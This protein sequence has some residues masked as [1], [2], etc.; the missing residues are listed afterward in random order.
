MER[1][2]TCWMVK[3]EEVVEWCWLRCWWGEWPDSTRRSCFENE[4]FPQVRWR[5][6]QWEGAICVTSNGTIERRAFVADQ[7]AAAFLPVTSN[8]AILKLHIAQRTIETLPP[9]DATTSLTLPSFL[10]AN[11][12]I[13]VEFSFKSRLIQR[14][15]FLLFSLFSFVETNP[16]SRI[17]CLCHPTIIDQIH[18]RP[19]VRVI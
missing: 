14:C 7:W 12:W 18:V 17:S 15:N 11:C 19:P 5:A 4:Q 9:I 1:Q 13:G 10:T 3:N 6:D 8:G 2:R 16:Y